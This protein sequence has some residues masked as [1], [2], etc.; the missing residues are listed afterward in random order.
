MRYL[1]RRTTLLISA[2]AEKSEDDFC[3]GRGEVW[4]GPIKVGDRFVA[5][6][7]DDEQLLCDLRVQDLSVA[8]NQLAVAQPGDLVDFVVVG[9]GAGALGVATLLIGE[10]MEVI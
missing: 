3:R 1:E 6:M 8:G 4:L 5:A 7:K 9:T 10:Q 2:V